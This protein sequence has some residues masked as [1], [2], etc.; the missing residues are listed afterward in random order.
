MDL[1]IFLYWKLLLNSYNLN[2]IINNSFSLIFRFKVKMWVKYISF[3]SFPFGQRKKWI[4]WTSNFESN[5][6]R[7]GM[8]F[9]PPLYICNCLIICPKVLMRNSRE[10]GFLS[11]FNWFLTKIEQCFQNTFS[12]CHPPYLPG[13]TPSFPIWRPFPGK[14]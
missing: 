2:W 12:S 8:I 6:L 1:I 7:N 14:L 4:L 5:Y 11:W 3:T 13:H 10:S 9:F